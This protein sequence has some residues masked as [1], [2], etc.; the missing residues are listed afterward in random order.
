MTEWC[1][2]PD[3]PGRSPACHDQCEKYREWKGRLKT[4]KEY[5]Q[6]AIY[7]DK[8][9]RGD[10]EKE[11]WMAHKGQRS[12]RE[13]EQE[14]PSGNYAGG[15]WR[16]DGHKVCR[17]LPDAGGRREPLSKYIIYLLFL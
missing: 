3:C 4:E 5:T 1:C 7:R 6:N 15:L 8:V 2:K 14:K 10:Y 13:N 9:N 11:G 12:R 16:R 17:V